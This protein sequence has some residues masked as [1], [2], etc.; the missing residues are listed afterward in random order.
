MLQTCRLFGVILCG[1]AA[2]GEVHT[3]GPVDGASDDSAA[4]GP[5][6]VTVQVSPTGDDTSDGVA[7]PVKTLKRAFALA[8]ADGRITRVA[9][10][11]GTYNA[12]NG[13]S[14]PYLVP[15]NLTIAGSGATL[16]GATSSDGLTLESGTLDGIALSGFVVAVTVNGTA[17]LT[18][19]RIQASNIGVKARKTA[20]LTVTRLSIAGKA[21]ACET[22]ISAEDTAAVSAANVTTTM[23][24]TTVQMIDQSTVELTSPDFAGDAGCTNSMLSVSGKSL[25]ITG[26]RIESG[27][28]GIQ[29]T[30]T[31]PPTVAT[32]TDTN[33]GFMSGDG[34]LGSTVALAMT[35]GDLRGSHRG[36][37]ATGGSWTFTNVSIIQNTTLAIQLGG[38]SASAPGTLNAHGCDISVNGD[39]IQLSSF[40]AA[41]LGTAANP[42]NNRFGNNTNI[43]LNLAGTAG[44][45]LVTAIGNTWRASTQGSDASGKYP[46]TATITGPVAAA[47][48]NNFAV[49]AG[50]R[51]VR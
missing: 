13:E 47:Q 51:L 43:N 6:A 41:D 10:A 9:L 49:A 18:D 44:A 24:G 21:G 31:S 3:M 38:T 42:G 48:G 39:G 17:A 19:V 28:T 35:G 37:F 15:A 11:S 22:G 25:K 50:W 32:F 8:V 20:T 12:A 30:G 36:L 29:F 34:L 45:T 27:A 4:D 14:F 16:V 1:A 33:I 23:L 7:R 46:T 26:G 2:C 5:P 40:A